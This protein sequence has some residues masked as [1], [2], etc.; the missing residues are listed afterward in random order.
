[1]YLNFLESNSGIHEQYE[2]NRQTVGSVNQVAEN[3]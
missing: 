3:P 2:D 1:M